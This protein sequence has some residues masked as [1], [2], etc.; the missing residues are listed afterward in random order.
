MATEG[1]LSLSLRAQ[2][3]SP[4]RGSPGSHREEALLA[5][6]QS[7]GSAILSCR[8]HFCRISGCA[9][10]LVYPGSD[11]EPRELRCL[12]LHLC[13]HPAG[14]SSRQD[15]RSIFFPRL[16]GF[17][18]AKNFA[19]VPKSI[20]QPHSPSPCDSP[21]LWARARAQTLTLA[22]AR[23]HA[24]APRA[25]ESPAPLSRSHSPGRRYSHR[26]PAATGR[27]LSAAAATVAEGKASA[28]W[29][30]LAASCL[31][32]SPG[33]AEKKEDAKARRSR[34]APGARLCA[35]G[36]LRSAY[37]GPRILKAA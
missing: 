24:R 11:P 17:P 6:P 2:P 9:L 31:G 29:P 12:Y 20:S 22:G 30:R 27:P 21:T 33:E 32:Q 16:Y 34:A 7:R 8:R 13:R 28:A 19:S 36:C 35:A 10:H 26:L 4:D 25:A 23:A 37:R 1:F 18:G 5:P 14:S 3:G 15:G